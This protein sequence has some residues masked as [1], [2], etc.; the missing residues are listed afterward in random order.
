MWTTRARPARRASTSL[1]SAVGLLLLGAAPWAGA[2]GVP[3]IVYFA[4]GSNVP[5]TDWT[6]SYEYDARPKDAS[7]VFGGS[8][9]RESRD[10]FSGKKSLP[11]AGTVL[12]VQYREFDETREVDGETREVHVAQATGLV[13]TVDGK[14]RDVKLEAPRDELL[15]PEGVEKGVEVSALGLDLEGTTLTGTKRSFCIAGYVYNVQCRPE[16]AD[17]IVKIEFPR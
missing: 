9:R 14:K 1:A 12:E 15:V 5:L 3:I 8:S 11:T 17:R 2:Q 10:L 6:F 4:D 13:M 7:P 16:A